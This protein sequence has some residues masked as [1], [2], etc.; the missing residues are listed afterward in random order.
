MSLRPYVHLDAVLADASEGHRVPLSEAEAHH[1]QRV[2]RLSDGA[3]L[4]VADGRGTFA[5]GVLAGRDVELT[6][7]PRTEPAPVPMLHVAQALPKGRKADEVVRQVTELGA[8]AIT[9][10][11]TERS[12]ARLD[13]AKAERVRGRW[14]AVARAASEQ[15]RRPRRPRVEGPVSMG[16]LSGDGASLLVAQP[17]APALPSVLLGLGEVREVI[18]AIGPEGGWSPAELDALRSRHGGHLVGL[19]PSILRTEHAA[20][21][22]VAV[23]A[24]LLGRW[25]AIP[26]TDPDRV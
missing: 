2:L 1:L 17:Q 4:R 25:V 10:L 22:A 5:D 16:S 26:P 12:V 23:T 14:Q 15:A 21:A 6:E 19:G 7:R 3:E 13:G 8:D 18:L 9:F 20:A 24:A 11:V